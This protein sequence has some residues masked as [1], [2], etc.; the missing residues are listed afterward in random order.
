[1]CSFK[2]FQKIISFFIFP[3]KLEYRYLI[4]QGHILLILMDLI[5]IWSLF[6]LL[7][8]FKNDSLRFWTT[9]LAQRLFILPGSLV[10]Y[11]I[12]NRL[13]IE[14]GESFDELDGRSFMICMNHTSGFDSW[15]S[16]V[17][18]LSNIRRFLSTSNHWCVLAAPERL[19]ND[20]VRFLAFTAGA[21]P[22]DRKAGIEQY[23]LQDT[24]RLIRE[25]R[26]KIVLTVY[27][28]GTR[29][30]TGL[31]AKKCKA[32]VGWIQH[33]TQIPVLPVYHYGFNK[34]PGPFNT[35]HVMIGKP[36]Y[37]ENYKNAPAEPMTWKLISQ[38]I[39]ESLRTLEQK[40]LIEKAR[41]R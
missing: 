28:E 9:Y 32:G 22:V 7:N 26:R 38:E 30:K 5:F 33:S 10:F 35:L 27:P 6:L 20:A 36:L 16:S 13:R 40:V 39:L 23:G 8:N 41:R 3:F 24:V 2:K 17:Y 21:I 12:L 14:G 15:S 34:L 29:S 19:L 11:Q 4:M 18:F 25:E 1:M 37:F 31:L